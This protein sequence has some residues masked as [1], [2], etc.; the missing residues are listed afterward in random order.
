MRKQLND[1]LK[2]H[3]QRNVKATRGKLGISQEDMADRLLMAGRTYIDLEQG[4][5]C[6]SALTLVLYLIYVCADPA[7]FL[8]EL[9]Q[10]LEEG[11]Y[12]VA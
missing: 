10:M 9:K 3:F 6:C 1:I 5:N 8:A 7:V 4:K 11:A 12:Q 2:L